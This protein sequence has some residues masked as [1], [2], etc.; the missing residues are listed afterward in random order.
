M[1]F[2][3]EDASPGVRTPGAFSHRVPVIFRRLHRFQQMD[4]E[5]AAW[6]LT[7]LCLA[8]KRVYRNVYFHKQTKNTWARDDPAIL[9]LIAACLCVSAVAW[10]VV[11]SL[12]VLEAIWLA[13]LMVGRDYLLTGI[14]VATILWFTSNRLLLSP[15]SH[16]TPADSRVEWAYAFDVHTNAFFPLYLTLYLAQLFLLPIILRDRWV[17]IWVGNTLYLAAFT[18]YIYGV[19][20]GLSALPFL[21]RSELLLSPLLPL[22]TGYIVSLVGFNVAKH[23]LQAYFGS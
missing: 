21:V 8:P 4:F 6:Q 11:Y 14:A 9:V 13:L 10:S 20:L 17:C 7:Y 5:L 1:S 19:Y 2:S 22:F 15:P 16:S 12:G 18:Q 3:P 23:V